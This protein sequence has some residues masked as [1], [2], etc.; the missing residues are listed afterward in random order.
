MSKYLIFC[1]INRKKNLPSDNDKTFFYNQI[2]INV[3]FY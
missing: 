3:E 2:V 1:S